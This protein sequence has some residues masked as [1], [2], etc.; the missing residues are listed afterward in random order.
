MPCDNRDVNSVNIEFS[1]AI[2]EIECIVNTGS[3]N[4]IKSNQILFKVG[5]VHLKEKLARSYLPNYIL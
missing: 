3:S 5:N 4:Q 1:N 2:D